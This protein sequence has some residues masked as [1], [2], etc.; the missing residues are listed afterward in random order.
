VPTRSWQR[1]GYRPTNADLGV[2]RGP[3]LR[4]ELHL[5]YDWFRLVHPDSRMFKVMTRLT[6]PEFD[7]LAAL[8]NDELS[9]PINLPRMGQLRVTEEDNLQRKPRG[10]RFDN[11]NM[12]F[13][14]LFLFSTPSLQF[15][16]VAALT[17]LSVASV[18]N[19]FYHVL[20][21]VVGVLGK[22]PNKVIQWPDRQRR[23]ELGQ[24]G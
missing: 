1:T 5:L 3:H 20:F 24:V 19:Y 7:T 23:A 2:P 16:R 14:F 17:G 18:H 9:K 15:E 12:L 10:R 4:K 8:L 6:F 21:A 22:G 13:L 11:K